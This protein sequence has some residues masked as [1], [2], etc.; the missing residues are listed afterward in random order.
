MAD[1]VFYGKPL[2]FNPND[3]R[4]YWDGKPVPSVTTIINRL[5]KPLLIQWA[6]DCAVKYIREAVDDS[7]LVSFS[8][9]LY[10]RARK[11]HETIRDTAGDI[12]TAVHQYARAALT[13]KPEPRDLPPGAIEA[14]AAFWLWVERHRIEPIAV[15][16]RVF[17]RRHMYAGTCDFFGRINGMLSVLDFKTGKGVY[18]EAWWQTSGY[19]L[20]LCEELPIE[21]PVI[22][23]IVHL[24]K[25]TGEC[26][27][28]MR[29]V[30]DGVLDMQVWRS[31]VELDKALRTARKHPQ[32]KKAA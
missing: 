25:N 20:A 14:C 18:D 15:E 7:G 11:A 22:R 26:T 17:S 13:G 27:A 5:S 32:P 19:E 24:D 3:H 12:G 2:R 8:D 31:L 21:E 28:H 6:A 9:A 29:D 4:Y 10:E 23:W 1:P 16:R 30:A